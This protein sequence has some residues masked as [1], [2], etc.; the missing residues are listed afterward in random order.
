M[1]AEKKLNDIISRCSKD[2][3]AKLTFSDFWFMISIIIA[4][5]MYCDRTTGLVEYCYELLQRKDRVKDS[6]VER[7]NRLAAYVHNF[8][9]ASR[10]G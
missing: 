4:S 8:L 6:Q 2:K 3:P 10:N 9:K 1:N 7:I 5:H